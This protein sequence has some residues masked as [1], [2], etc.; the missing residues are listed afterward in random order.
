MLDASGQF[1]YV[2]LNLDTQT[3]VQFD[4]IFIFQNVWISNL[5]QNITKKKNPQTSES[6][7]K[8]SIE[9]S[10]YNMQMLHSFLSVIRFFFSLLF[11]CACILNN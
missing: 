2:F 3:V 10:C 11:S 8:F 9:Y 6:S 5:S 7:L 1:G 4:L